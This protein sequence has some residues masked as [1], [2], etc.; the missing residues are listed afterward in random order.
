MEQYRVEPDQNIKL[1]EWKTD[2]PDLDIDKTSSSGSAQR[3]VSGAGQTCRRS[4]R[5]SIYTKF[6]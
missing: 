2:E 6:S 5:R 3:F 4:L 1:D